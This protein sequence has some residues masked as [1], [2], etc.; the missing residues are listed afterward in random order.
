MI[1]A[2]NFGYM[3]T[4]PPEP[5]TQVTICILCLG[6]FDSIYS[7]VIYSCITLVVPQQG[8]SVAI[9]IALN[10]QNV[11]LTILPIYFGCVNESRS[12]QAYNE[13][14]FSLV[15]L[16]GLACIC[17]ILVIVVN[18][19]TGKRLH[20]PENYHRVLEAKSRAT[21]NFKNCTNV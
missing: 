3:L 9:G 5:S 17:S 10:I 6:L 14:L 20:L 19:R 2:L 7:T 1:A 21:S 11:V 18:F 16:A 12:I 15:I 13:S 8:T 4:L